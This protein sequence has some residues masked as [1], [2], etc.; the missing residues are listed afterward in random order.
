M[1]KKEQTFCHLLKINLCHA[2][3]QAEE[4]VFYADTMEE[5]I[6]HLLNPVATYKP[7][8]EVE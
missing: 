8:V 2:Q 4:P 3:A 1:T 5:V 6:P 7:D